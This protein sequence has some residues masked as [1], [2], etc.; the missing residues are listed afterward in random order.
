MPKQVKELSATAISKAKSK[1]KDYKLSDGKGLYLLVTAKG[2][3]YWRFDYSLNGKRKTLS[4]GTFPE[5]SLAD[6]REKRTAAREQVARG[7]DPG[8]VKRIDATDKSFEA[9]ARDWHAKNSKIWKPNYAAQIIQRLENDVFC[10]IGAKDIREIT[11]QEILRLLQ[12]IELRG[13]VE[14]AHRVKMLISQIM[15]FAVVSGIAD[16]DPSVDLKG[17]LTPS[18]VVHYGSITEPA[19]VGGLLRAIDGYEGTFIVK[20]ALQFAA[21]VFVRPGELRHAEWAEI[22]FDAALWSI[23]AHKMKMGLPHI[24]PLSRQA[25][26]ILTELHTLTG[27]GKYLFPGGRTAERPLSDAAINAALRRMGF[28][29][30]EMTGHGFRA[31]ARTILDEVLK[32]RV[33]FIEHQLAHTVK[34]PNGRAYNRTA[35]LEERAKMMQKWADYLEGLKAGAKVIPFPTAANR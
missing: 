20:C 25:V 35:H 21:L 27:E 32:V 9:I 18:K 3:K 4:L 28:A 31:M 19:K 30:E 26:A 34:D 15:R 11:A 29:S 1:E 14:T 6:A 12:L 7:I 33:D 8:E 2:G 23:P 13:A 16:R 22:D 5:V 24:V 10:K 17:A